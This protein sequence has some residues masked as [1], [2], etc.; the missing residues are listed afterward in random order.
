MAGVKNWVL[1]L[2]NCP[3]SKLSTLTKYALGTEEVLLM[4]ENYPIS[5]HETAGIKSI[6][7]WPS[8]N[9]YRSPG[10]YILACP[11]VLC[12]LEAP[13]FQSDNLMT[14]LE[15]HLPGKSL[16]VTRNIMTTVSPRNIDM[17]TD[18]ESR[19]HSPSHEHCLKLPRLQNC[20]GF[21]IIQ[22]L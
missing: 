1:F 16:G 12:Q 10:Q 20:L 6:T 18:S 22:R 21:W 9:S 13:C 2:L 11:F 17:S 14:S 5:W 8:I 3:L 7:P 19:H 4:K 15:S